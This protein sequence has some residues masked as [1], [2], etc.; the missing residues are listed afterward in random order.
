MR[1][2]PGC[3]FVVADAD[4]VEAEFCRFFPLDCDEREQVSH[5]L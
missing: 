1:T 4:G 5:D 3:H 2:E